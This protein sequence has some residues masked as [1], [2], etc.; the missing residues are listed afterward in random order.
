VPTK[1]EV[2]AARA[3]ETASR[4]EESLRVAVTGDPKGRVRRKVLFMVVAICVLV[5]LATDGAA[6]LIAAGLGLMALLLLAMND[7]VVPL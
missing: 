7:D 2:R 5:G 4:V 1:A 3:R 6:G